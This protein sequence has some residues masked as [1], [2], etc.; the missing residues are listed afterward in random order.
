MKLP[1]EL[2]TGE[3]VLL[4][5][6]RH[7][8]SFIPKIV[9]I[10]VVGFGT[11][12]LLTGL[13]RSTIGLGSTTWKVAFAVDGLWLAYW[14]VRGYFLWFRYQNDIWVVTNQRVIDSVKRNWVNHTMASADLVDIQDIAVQRS[15]L[16]PTAFNYGDVRCQTAG[17]LE[18]F[19][20][21]GIPAPAK[22]LELVD[23]SRDAARRELL[24]IPGRP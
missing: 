5:T 9:A 19:V 1:F 10:A 21:A 22:V 18:N 6:R 20:L 16:L 2:Q 12:M 3:Q 23:A 8:I 4:F 13:V 24:R 11:P 17:E 14:A 7:W 15:G